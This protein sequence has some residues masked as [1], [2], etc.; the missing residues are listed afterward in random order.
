MSYFKETSPEGQQSVIVGECDFLKKC[1]KMSPRTC[2]LWFPST[3]KSRAEVFRSNLSGSPNIFREDLSSLGVGMTSL[4]FSFVFNCET[5]GWVQLQYN[6]RTEIG[7]LFSEDQK[8]LVSQV[9]NNPRL[10]RYLKDPNGMIE[11]TQVSSLILVNGSFEANHSY[12]GSHFVNGS[13]FWMHL[14]FQ[15]CIVPKGCLSLSR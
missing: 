1:C 4:S 9:R 8:I 5:W 7:D 6:Y 12:H 14:N 15:M 11:S 2:L 10:P 3:L 13:H